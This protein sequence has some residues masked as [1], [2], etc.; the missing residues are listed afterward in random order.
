MAKNNYRIQAYDYIVNAIN[1]GDY[2]P[3]ALIAENEIAEKLSISRTPVREALKTLEAEGMVISY[4]G[5]GSFVAYITRDDIVEICQLRFLMENY[6]L[7]RAIK[8]ITD[9]ELDKCEALLEEAKRDLN[10]EVCMRADTTLHNLIIER[11]GSRYVASLTQQLNTL[12]SRFRVASSTNSNRWAA[13]TEE[14]LEILRC[15]RLR[16]FEKAS[17]ALKYHLENVTEGFCKVLT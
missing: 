7:E 14:H 15:I 9:Q 8:R 1:H 4:P 17:A 12:T 6:A 5:R 3:G 11:S 13:S 2:K 10:S 16:D